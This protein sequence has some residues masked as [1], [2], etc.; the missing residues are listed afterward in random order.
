EGRQNL[1]VRWVSHILQQLVASLWRDRHVQK[2]FA[3]AERAYAERRKALLHALRERGFAAHGTSGLNV[4]IPLREESA[5]VNALLK[6]GWAVNAGERYRVK[7]GP[8]IRVTVAA[9][10][11]SDAE[12]FAEDLGA[13]VF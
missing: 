10:D 8:A 2:L 1:G 3:T 4:W 6:R 12:K 5:V 13:I 11:E 9:L 7:S